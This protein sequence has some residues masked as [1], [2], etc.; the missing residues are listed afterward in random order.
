MLNHQEL[1]ASHHHVPNL[2][3]S[4]PAHLQIVDSTPSK[5][6]AVRLQKTNT[7]PPPLEVPHSVATRLEGL[8]EVSS[9]VTSV[10]NTSTMSTRNEAHSSHPTSVLNPSESVAGLKTLSPMRQLDPIPCDGTHD[11]TSELSDYTIDTA[12]EGSDAMD[13]D[14][15]EIPKGVG[16]QNQCVLDEDSSN[17]VLTRCTA[18]R[19]STTLNH[20]PYNFVNAHSINGKSANPSSRLPLV[21]DD[22]PQVHHLSLQSRHSERMNSEE[23]KKG[24]KDVSQ[25]EG[26]HKQCFSYRDSSNAHSSDAFPLQDVISLYSPTSEHQEFTAIPD[27]S[28]SW[29]NQPDNVSHDSAPIS[30]SQHKIAVDLEPSRPK[31]RTMGSEGIAEDAGRPIQCFSDG[32]S[33]N[34]TVTS[35]LVPATSASV[36]HPQ[37]GLILA[38]S[39]KEVFT[40]G[41]SNAIHRDQGRNTVHESPDSAMETRCANSKMLGHHRGILEEAGTHAQHDL[42]TAESSNTRNSSLV[43]IHADHSSDLLTSSHQHIVISTADGSSSELHSKSKPRFTLDNLSMP[44][45]TSEEVSFTEQPVREANPVPMYEDNQ[46]SISDEA[47][48]NRCVSRALSSASTCSTT[49]RSSSIYANQFDPCDM[50]RDSATSQR[51]EPADAER[52]RPTGMDNDNGISA[53]IGEENESCSCPRKTSILAINLTSLDKPQLRHSSPH[54]CC[55][56]H[57]GVMDSKTLNERHPCVVGNFGMQKQHNLHEEISNTRSSAP[58]SIRDVESS[59]S[60][61]NSQQG[62]AHPASAEGTSAQSQSDSISINQLNSC[63]LPHQID[64]PPRQPSYPECKPTMT[65][66]HLK[67]LPPMETGQ[68]NKDITEDLQDVSTTLDKFTICIQFSDTYI[69]LTIMPVLIAFVN[70][71]QP[72]YFEEIHTSA[73][74]NL[75]QVDEG[76]DEHANRKYCPGGVTMGITCIHGDSTVNYPILQQTPDIQIRPSDTGLSSQIVH[77]LTLSTQLPTMTTTCH[78]ASSDGCESPIFTKTLRQLASNGK[79]EDLRMPSSVCSGKSCEQAEHRLD[80]LGKTNQRAMYR[81]TSNSVVRYANLEHV[82]SGGEILVEMTTVAVSHY[83]SIP[84]PSCVMIPSPT[85]SIRS[86]GNASPGVSDSNTVPVENIQKFMSIQNRRLLDEKDPNMTMHSFVTVTSALFLWRP[87]QDLVNANDAN[88]SIA[89]S[90]PISHN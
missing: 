68:N 55:S 27:D 22:P 56:E 88:I 90:C 51:N 35:T 64:I 32:R 10:C 81:E 83:G 5:S 50:V 52:V 1:L 3:P 57:E 45:G 59:Y 24:Q 71:N 87:L 7:Q 79:C 77:N 21:D 33:P 20:P 84:C 40:E 30:N 42:H 8:Q 43:A 74:M 72:R 13:K 9:T 80:D 62:L 54:S 66:D 61:P 76:F 39:I 44:A 48:S 37:Q 17:V 46:S 14:G 28:L 31:A 86:L 69:N 58:I 47:M 65:F 34:V 60:T 2:P 29:N 78:P 11:L 85:A 70:T 19:D 53:A 16:T 75:R 4:D 23:I 36:T 26:M 73:S 63:A 67:A 41:Q 89:Q 25:D 15:W 6:P 38:P 18:V 12:C 82:D 49:P